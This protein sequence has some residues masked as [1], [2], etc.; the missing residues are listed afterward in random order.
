M[1]S[2][3]SK[4]DVVSGGNRHS[5]QA[6]GVPLPMETDTPYSAIRPT[7]VGEKPQASR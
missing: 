2:V 7:S 3:G 6:L 1:L 5:A 4:K